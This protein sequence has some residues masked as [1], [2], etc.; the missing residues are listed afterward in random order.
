[1]EL[2][3]KESKGFDGG[4]FTGVLFAIGNRNGDTLKGLTNWSWCKDLLAQDFRR[5]VIDWNLLKSLTDGVL[6]IRDTRKNGISGLQ[7]TSKELVEKSVQA[8]QS[9]L[10]V[11]GVPLEYGFYKDETSIHDKINR[12]GLQDYAKDINPEQVW[13][14]LPN[15]W[16]QRQI[17]LQEIMVIYRSF[18]LVYDPN[19]D[20]FETLKNCKSPFKN[21]DSAQQGGY[22]DKDFTHLHRAYRFRT[23]LDVLKR[24]FKGELPVISDVNYGYYQI[25]GP[26]ECSP[27]LFK[28]EENDKNIKEKTED[29]NSISSTSAEQTSITFTTTKPAEEISLP[30]SG[31]AWFYH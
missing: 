10:N 18:S 31:P 29:N 19:K 8:I 21:A 11:Y 27:E 22:I 20:F 14:K 26:L 15:D 4:H 3:L 1:M 7:G 16:F 2:I 28:F 30:S 23:H 13:I 6:L 25:L 24:L 17:L 5:E 12:Y 9:L